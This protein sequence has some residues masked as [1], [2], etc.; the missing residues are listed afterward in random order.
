MCKWLQ[1]RFYGRGE[2]E[3]LCGVYS[4]HEVE[5]V[6]L[7]SKALSR[8]DKHK[9]MLLTLSGNCSSFD[10]FPHSSD[11]SV[12]STDRSPEGGSRRRIAGRS[13]PSL[14]SCTSSSDSQS[15]RSSGP[16]SASSEKELSSFVIEN[17]RRKSGVEK[18]TGGFSGTSS[19]ATVSGKGDAISSR[20]EGEGRGREDRSARDRTSR[21]RDRRS[22]KVRREAERGR[23][24]CRPTDA[25]SAFFTY[26]D[27]TR[28]RGHIR[29][30]RT[31][32]SRE[33][34]SDYSEEAAV[35]EDRVERAVLEECVEEVQKKKLVK[36][37]E[38]FRIGKQMLGGENARRFFT[39]APNYFVT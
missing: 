21:E 24:E 8:K 18:R 33:T 1:H 30:D 36:D 19:S 17:R 9:L 37:A 39:G 15:E 3:R 5:R 31:R 7:Q 13:R 22:G 20:G 12:S 4:P 35:W 26:E 14:L 25:A 32:R 16:A 23:S 28:G 6:V 27:G 2:L 38:N 29:R 11:S 10:K 34:R